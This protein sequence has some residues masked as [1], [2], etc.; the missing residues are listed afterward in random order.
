MDMEI[1]IQ[2]KTN[3]PLLKRTEVH[4][5]IHHEGE[6][7][8]KREL[9]RNELAG[10]LN[11]KKEN[12]M[13]SYMKSSFGATDTLGYAKIYKSLKEAEKGEKNYILKRNNVLVKEKKPAKEEKEKPTKEEGVAEKPKEKKEGGGEKT[14]D[15]TAEKP[16]EGEGES[17]KKPEEAAEKPVEETAEKPAEKEESAEKPKGKPDKKK[18]EQGIE[19]PEREEQPSEKE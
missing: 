12:I 16:A 3:N 8:P 9:V 11:V 19:K 1:D 15:E 7:T 13:V 10:K 18:M 17:T 4:F 14:V 2:S 6:S 5:I